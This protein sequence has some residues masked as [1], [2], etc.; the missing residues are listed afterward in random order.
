MAYPSDVQILLDEVNAAGRDLL[1]SAGEDAGTDPITDGP[2]TRTLITAA[3]NLIAGLQNPGVY[4]LELTWQTHRN[5]VVR[6]LSDLG[7]FELVPP[8]PGTATLQ[9][10]ASKTGADGQL[11][12]RLMRA[13]TATGIFVEVEPEVYRHNALSAACATGLKHELKHM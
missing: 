12:Y 5:S 6:A 4:M 9:E 13:L 11:L 1:R 7:V 10:L 2:A 8:Q 3:Q